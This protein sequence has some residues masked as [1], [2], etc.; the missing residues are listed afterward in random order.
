[1]FR[2]QRQDRAFGIELLLGSRRGPDQGAGGPAQ[3][4]NTVDE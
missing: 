2:F 1:M 3:V 4:S